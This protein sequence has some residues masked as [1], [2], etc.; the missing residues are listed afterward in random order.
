MADTFPIALRHLLEA[1]EAG[2]E[3]ASTPAPTQ[4]KPKEKPKDA[5]PDPLLT[6]ARKLLRRWD[7]ELVVTGEHRWVQTT[8]TRKRIWL[9]LPSESEESAFEEIE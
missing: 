8:G 4:P 5:E 3:Q 9:I 7:L 1:E 2:Q 6:L